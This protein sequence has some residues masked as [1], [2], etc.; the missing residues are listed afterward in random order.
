[1]RMPVVGRCGGALL[2]ALV[3]AS[4]ADAQRCR[5]VACAA[6]KERCEPASPC[7][8]A[9]DRERRASGFA[10]HPATDPPAVTLEEEPRV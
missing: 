3:L 2:A 4:P 1:M 5:M 7:R 9:A 6:A 10:C 8:G